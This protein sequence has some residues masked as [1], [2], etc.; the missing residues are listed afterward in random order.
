MHY[1]QGAYAMARWERTPNQ[2]K[3]IR[4]CLVLLSISVA[5]MVIS[6]IIDIVQNG[7]GTIHAFNI[8]PFSGIIVVMIIILANNKKNDTKKDEKDE[9]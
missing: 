7:W 2:L 9:K 5:I 1:I 6:T 3:V 4:V 8:A